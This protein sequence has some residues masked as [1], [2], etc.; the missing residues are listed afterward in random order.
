MVKKGSKGPSSLSI[1]GIAHVGLRVSNARKSRRFY[2]E[3]LGL[4]CDENKPGI[5]FLSSGSDLLV[6]YE[7]NKG[8][9][10]FHFGFT[11]NTRLQVEK[12]KEWLRARGVRIYEDI[13]ESGHPRSFK[14]RDPDGYWVEISSRR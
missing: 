5:A 13:I 11:V 12:W 4:K 6:L 8:R 14:F 3:I 2:K 10:G 9:S 1:G 7:K